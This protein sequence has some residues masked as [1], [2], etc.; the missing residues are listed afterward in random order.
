MGG[1][2]DADAWSPEDLRLVRSVVP[3]SEIA[4][5]HVHAIVAERD[6][7]APGQSTGAS[8]I[9]RPPGQRV[10]GP[11]QHGRPVAGGDDIEQAMDSVD[12]VNVCVAWRTKHNLGSRRASARRVRGQIMRTEIR[13]RLNDARGSPAAVDFARHDYAEESGRQDF[14]GLGKEITFQATHTDE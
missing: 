5:R 6:A 12:E 1:I 14:G 13:F 4:A 3:E 9:D 8:E 2:V 10:G 11:Q 7:E